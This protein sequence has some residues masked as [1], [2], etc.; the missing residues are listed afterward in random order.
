MF[1]VPYITFGGRCYALG[2][3]ESVLECMLRHGVAVRSSCR[4]GVCQSCVMRAIDGTPPPE[5]QK[6]LRESLKKH[7]HFLACQW[8]P[9]CD[10]EVRLP[11]ND[12]VPCISAKVVGKKK[13]SGRVVNLTLQCPTDFSFEAGQFINLLH[14]DCV[15]SY[16]IANVP[17]ARHR[18]ELHVY[19]VEGGRLSGWIHDQ[20]SVGDVVTVQ[21][22][23]GD[24]VYR[25]DAK[26]QP[27]LL[28]GTGCGL[29]A[30]RGVVYQALQ[31]GH[32]AP[33]YLYHGSR[34]IDGLYLF[35]EMRQ[36]EKEHPQFHYKAC[37]SAG[38][39]PAGYTSGRATDIALIEHPALQGW[40][41]YLCGNTEMVSATKRQAYLAGAAL[42]DIH[43]DPFEFS[44]R[45]SQPAASITE[46]CSI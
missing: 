37:L 36:L 27:L 19:R 4:S 5:A 41:I 17:D 6:G 11:G 25:A 23:F 45:I 38:D 18:L 35:E 8:R 10:V 22:P 16:S 39:A 1:A 30:L 14:D 3:G 46:D 34:S 15:R 2:E 24:C 26:R 20:L 13:L 33:M 43:A 40:Q 9:G 7:N 42:A 28:I 31:Q 44:Y 21:G 32:A 12:A 29:A